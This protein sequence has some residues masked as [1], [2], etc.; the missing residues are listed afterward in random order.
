M[1]CVVLS[2]LC[3]LC[4]ATATFPEAREPKAPKHPFITASVPDF[5][6]D[7]QTIR[8][9]TPGRRQG[10]LGPLCARR[11]SSAGVTRL[12]W[13]LTHVLPFCGHLFPRQTNTC[14][15]G[16]AAAWMN[17][18][19]SP[20]WGRGCCWCSA[21]RCWVHSR[22]EPL[23]LTSRQTRDVRGIRTRTPSGAVQ[24]WMEIGQAFQLLPPS[25]AA[26]VCVTE[27]VPHLP[28]AVD[29]E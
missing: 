29:K 16:S 28:E 11:E 5:L 23:L 18:V 13:Q 2:P 4:G 1:P 20:L 9:K 15:M 17:L 26:A 6:S 10:G 12:T 14:S 24:K 3:E 8:F 7:F 22:K 21:R 25:A 27:R 19:L